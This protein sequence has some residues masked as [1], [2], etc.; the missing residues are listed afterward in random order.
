MLPLLFAWLALAPVM[1]VAAQGQAP[2]PSVK[3]TD[4]RMLYQVQING[5]L[6]DYVLVKCTAGA[7]SVPYEDFPPDL[8]AKLEAVRP[9]Q[10][11]RVIVTGDANAAIGPFD[12]GGKSAQPAGPQTLY[13][14]GRIFLP[15][16]SAA[17][18]P[19]PDVLVYAV[20]PADF[21]AF[22]QAR[23]K[24][25]GAAIADA[26]DKMIKATPGDAQKAA[27]TDTLLTLY[28]SFDPGPPSVATAATDAK[29]HF[30]VSCHELQVILVARTTV[31]T[32]SGFRYMVW[33]VPANQAEPTFMS[34]ENVVTP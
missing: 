15:G 24:K 34:T 31:E 29:G 7:I 1:P 16:P 21:T 4:G 10:E 20:R 14:P 19:L 2:V 23:L 13:Y 11:V 18:I 8:R 28:A 30:T 17:G 22:N 26:A 6:R 5:T 3:L 12:P 27:I 33:A 32:A 9:K 25:Y